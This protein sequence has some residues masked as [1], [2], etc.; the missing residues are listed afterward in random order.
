MRVKPV[1]AAMVVAALAGLAAFLFLPPGQAW[2]AFWVL[3][4]L[5]LVLAILLVLARRR[6]AR[7][8][9]AGGMDLGRLR[10]RDREVSQDDTA[11]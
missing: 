7:E 3:A 10:E 6:A 5:E 11:W 9:D 4:A 1:L 8:Q 2:L